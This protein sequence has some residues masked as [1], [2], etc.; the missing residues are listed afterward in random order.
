MSPQ[1]KIAGT[2][3][4]DDVPYTVCDEEQ[5]RYRRL[6]GVPKKSALSK[7]KA[8]RRESHPA[9]FDAIKERRPIGATTDTCAR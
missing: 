7:L 6:F 1:R 3:P 5:S 4:T 9:T 8:L 2:P